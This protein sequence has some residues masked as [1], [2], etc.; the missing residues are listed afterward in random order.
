MKS[1]GIVRQIDE[2]GRIVLPKEL[3]D[4]L[5]IKIKDALEISLDA[6]RIIIKKYEKSCAVC[7]LNVDLLPFKEKLICVKC[8]EV[9]K[10]GF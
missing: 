7:G 2:L 4:I 9:V 1:T 5:D 3:R 8:I 6:N 10:Q